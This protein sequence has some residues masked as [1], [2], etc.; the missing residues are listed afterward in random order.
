M[1]ATPIGNKD[2][3]TLRALQV[4]RTVERIYCEDTSRSGV[5]LQLHGVRTPLYRYDK[6]SESK[7]M[8]EIVDRVRGGAEIALISDAG[9]PLISDPGAR[10]VAALQ[11]EG[12]P[13]TVVS[14]ACALV[15]AVVASG[16][17]TERFFMVGFLPA[18][19]KDRDALLLQIKDLH[20]TLVFYVPPHDI[21]E[22]LAYL[23]DKLG[24]RQ[25]ALCRELTKMYEQVVRFALGAV[26]DFVQKGEMV[27]C[28]EGKPNVVEQLSEQEIIE[29]VR[30]LVQ[31]GVDKK[32][33]IKQV[34]QKQ[35]MQK[36][37]VYNLYE[38]TK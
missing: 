10:L 3:I 38:Q 25:V 7:K 28:V 31:E 13:Y 1:V 30:Q 26:P 24:A 15:N 21:L 29:Q 18:K 8:N 11:K 32:E 23:Y 14:G 34:A 9:M 20:A 37:V 6:F 22:Y 19:N 16:L 12:L 27:L 36:S 17:D 33:A 2:E 4:L 5:L 35:K